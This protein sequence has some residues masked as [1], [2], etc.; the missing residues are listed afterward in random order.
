M[1][2]YYSISLAFCV[3]DCDLRLLA[4]TTNVVDGYYVLSLDAFQALPQR[5][6]E[7][8]DVVLMAGQ[9]LFVLERLLEN[10]RGEVRRSTFYVDLPFRNYSGIAGR[11]TDELGRGIAG[12]QVFCDLKDGIARGYQT[13]SDVNGRYNFIKPDEPYTFRAASA[14]GVSDTVDSDGSK[15]LDSDLVVRH[16]EGVLQ[17]RVAMTSG[18]E[19]A[20]CLLY[21]DRLASG[22]GSE[23]LG[24]TDG[25][26]ITD[27]QGGFRITGLSPGV[28]TLDLEDLS[29]L[30]SGR[31]RRWLPL[32]RFP[33]G[34]TGHQIVVQNV[35]V[36]VESAPEPHPELDDFELSFCGAGNSSSGMKS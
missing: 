9:S 27:P 5:L 13:F 33:C 28:Y 34:S 29:L 19:M 2:G 32:G 7:H 25:V 23:S 16:G 14:Q 22:Q 6:R 11:V 8:G 12:A 18:A 10:R 35:C 26:A 30:R 24:R 4:T 15:P 1:T 3:E 31:G 17:G 36:R 20:Y 21:F